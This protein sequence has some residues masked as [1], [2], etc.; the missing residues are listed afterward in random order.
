MIDNQKYK[1][2]VENVQELEA[3]FLAHEGQLRAGMV[4][5]LT[6]HL[7]ECEAL[8]STILDNEPDLV[9]R[10]V[11]TEFKISTSKFVK[12][13][14][15]GCSFIPRDIANDTPSDEKFFDSS[16]T[17]ISNVLERLR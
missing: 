10:L 4:I 7:V 17:L 16:V 14:L 3:S 2:F 8:L 13:Y 9:K 11:C 12:R 1:E 6:R 5:L 15:N